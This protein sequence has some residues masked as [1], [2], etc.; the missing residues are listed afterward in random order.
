M[1]EHQQRRK[2]LIRFLLPPKAI[3]DHSQKWWE[4]SSTGERKTNMYENVIMSHPFPSSSLFICVQSH[5]DTQANHSSVSDKQRLPFDMV[6]SSLWRIA[7]LQLVNLTC[8]A[9]NSNSSGHREGS[10]EMRRGIKCFTMFMS[11]SVVC[12]SGILRT[13][14]IKLCS[15]LLFHD[16][17]N[18][19]IG[20][21]SSSTPTVPPVLPKALCKQTF[22]ELS[23]L[24]EINQIYFRHFSVIEMG[25][26]MN[27]LAQSMVAES[28][29]FRSR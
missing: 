11:S 5:Y 28:L 7:T 29:R 26:L 12:E 14:N 1:N 6:K 24:C 20:L 9:T 23:T 10:G 15:I 13:R 27:S 2:R 18:K 8:I 3:G 19:I 25:S 16:D 4:P 21:E 22:F 17:L